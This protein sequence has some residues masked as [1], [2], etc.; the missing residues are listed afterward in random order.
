MVHIVLLVLL[1]FAGGAV[2]AEGDPLSEA[3]ALQQQ[4]LTAYRAGRY[5]DLEPLLKRSI[6]LLEAR[7]GPD[8]P[9]VLESLDY[10]A[11]VYAIQGRYADAEAVQKRVLAAREKAPGA[12]RLE[13]AI[14]LNSLAAFYKLQGRYAEAEAMFRRAL[15]I[16]ETAANPPAEAVASVL[17]NLALIYHSQGRYAEAEPLYRRAIA[18]AQTTPETNRL[19]GVVARNNLA[20]LLKEEGRYDEAEPLYQSVLGLREQAATPL[21]LAASLN[22][23]ASLYDAEARYDAAEPLYR[24]ALE[25]REAVL[26][27]EHPDVAQSLNNLASIDRERRRYDEAEPLLQRALEIREKTLPP[28]HP[29][30]AAA[31]NN[32][33]AVQLSQGRAEEALGTSARAVSAL[34]SHLAASA[35]RN[36]D[37]AIAESRKSRIYV[38]NHIAIGYAL[39]RERPERHAAIATDSFRMAQFVQASNTAQAIAATAARFATA[40]NALAAVIREQQDLNGRR[41]RLD[42]EIVKTASK[43]PGERNAEA[44]KQLRASL[45]DTIKRVEALDARIAKEFPEYA[46]FSN[47]KPLRAEEAQALLAPDEALLAYLAAGDVTWLWVLRRD[48]IALRKV[49]IGAKALAHAVSALRGALDPDRNPDSAPFPAKDAHALYQKLLGPALSLLD[50]VHHL[51]LVPDGA[52]ESL[53]LGVLVTKPPEHDP[54][55]LADHRDI[56]WLARDYAITVLPAVTSLRVLRQPGKLANAEEPFLGIGNPVL[57]GKPGAERGAKLASLFRGA[58]ANVDN[59]RK[60]EALPETADELQA[61]AKTLGA[62]DKDLL[63]GDQASEPVM[64]QMPLD[65]YRVIQFATHG[66]VSGDLPGLAE[67]ALVLTPPKDATPEN[68]GLL[69]ASKVATLK[70][71]ADT[72]VL[73]ACNT[74]AGDGTPDAGGLSGLAKAFFYAGARSLLVSHWKVPSNS[75]VKLM[76]DTFAALKEEPKIGRAEALR[77]AEMAMLDPSNPPEFAHPMAWAAFVLAGEGGAGR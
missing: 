67:P 9:K 59:V 64:R 27:R 12:D 66:L 29:D 46:E 4:A 55:S 40:D 43:A 71:N 63:L 73:S 10:L 74:A 57:E 1:L 47:P 24:R 49:D 17:S 6:E 23:L 8:D 52:L 32:L 50:D 3:A 22:N 70:L 36:A 16:V 68:D 76:T 34:Q 61:I 58:L 14:S 20:G 5:G 38:A 53:P 19:F 2:G 60:L 69:T 30:I 56:A 44:E 31:F 48:D 28:D 65:H 37:A 42:A 72:V 51:L 62:D 41:Q 25:I 75:T 11:E 18:V 45:D 35:T 7:L 54:R 26:G 15:D 13:L 39:A 77:R 33:A 21:D